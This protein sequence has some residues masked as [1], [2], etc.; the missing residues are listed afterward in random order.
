[1]SRIK[2]AVVDNEFGTAINLLRMF[3]YLGH[4]ARLESDS[5]KLGG[6][7]HLILPGVGS[8]SDGARRLESSGFSEAIKDF[9]RSGKPILGVCL[10]MQL[11]GVGS[12]EGPGEGLALLEFS[13]TP[14][15]KSGVQ[16][17]HIG[18]N[19]VDWVCG[20]KPRSYFY[21]NHSFCVPEHNASAVGH[22]FCERTFASAVREGNI[23]GVQFHPEKSHRFGFEFIHYYVSEFTL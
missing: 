2:V 9:A 19:S 11:L 17:P 6:Y 1:M 22:S 5:S 3:N 18:W 16:R 8:F 12:S 20:D 4:E 15:I 7:S 21:F 23:M 13:T 14:V 10:G